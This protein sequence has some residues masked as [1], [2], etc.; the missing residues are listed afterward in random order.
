MKCFNNLTLIHNKKT[1]QISMSSANEGK[2]V[3]QPVFSHVY[4]IWALSVSRDFIVILSPVEKDFVSKQ[5]SEVP[6]DHKK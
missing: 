1:G 4:N 3:W 2:L 5:L 6:V